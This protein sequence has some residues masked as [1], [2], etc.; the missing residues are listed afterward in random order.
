MSLGDVVTTVIDVTGRPDKETYIR[1]SVTSL[2]RMLAG[3]KDHDISLVDAPQTVSNTLTLHTIVTPLDL[4]EVAYIRPVPFQ[5]FLTKINPRK[6][7]LNGQQVVNCYYRRGTDIIVNLQLGHETDTLV[8]GYFAHPP[9]L[10]LDTDTNWI[11]DSY[12]DVLIDLL[13]AKVFRVT[14]DITSAR[15]VEAGTIIRIQQILD[16]ASH[17]INVL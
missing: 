12:Q 1:A 7:M 13:A 15:A 4:R 16:S 5:A 3:L 17:D 11:L 9:A 8:F 6:T 2:I 14:G 10:T